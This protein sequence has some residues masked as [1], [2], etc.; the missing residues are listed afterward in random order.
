MPCSF[1]PNPFS[2]GDKVA[3]IA[4]S[5]S[6]AT[7]SEENRKIAVSNLRKLGL[8]VVFGQHV[9]ETDEFDSSSIKSRVED[10]NWAFEDEQ[11]KGILTA[12]GGFSSNQ[13]LRYLNYKLIKS[14]PKAL[15]GFSDA[16]ALLNA[17]YAK[18]GLVV[19]SGPHFCTFEMKLGLDF[20]IDY[21]KKCLMSDKPFKVEQSN[22]WSDDPLW[23]DQESRRFI[24]NEGYQT[25]L[26]NLPYLMMSVYPFLDAIMVYEIWAFPSRNVFR[27]QIS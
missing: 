18:T 1:A 19:Y 8:T 14:N 23:L 17:I 20:T 22:K 26:L 24:K 10:I 16:T 5:W 4:P 6:M 2:H 3:V 27:N 12:I 7:I 9:E 25:N 11:I 15:C 21:F 13:L